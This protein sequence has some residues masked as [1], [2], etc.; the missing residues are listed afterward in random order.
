MD[1]KL[2][3]HSETNNR[4]HLNL[5]DWSQPELWELEKDIPGYSGFDRLLGVGGMGAVYRCQQDSLQRTV[6]IKI[7]PRELGEKAD[8]RKR[9]ERE[10]KELAALEHPNIV[11]VF[12]RGCSE[13]GLFYLVMEYVDGV[14]L[15]YV[16]EHKSISLRQTLLLMQKVCAALC[17]AHSKGVIHRDIKPENILISR[18]NQVRVCDFGLVKLEPNR[19]IEVTRLTRID[20]RVGTPIYA[21]PETTAKEPSIDQR[22]DIYSLGKV[23]LECLLGKRLSPAATISDAMVGDF[24]K[25]VGRLALKSISEAPEER[26]QSIEEFSN[27][28]TSILKDKPKP[29][30]ALWVATAILLAGAVIAVAVARPPFADRNESPTGKIN[31]NYDQPMVSKEILEEFGIE[32]ISE[33]PTNWEDFGGDIV[34]SNWSWR[35]DGLQH[36][37]SPGNSWA[38]DIFTVD[39]GV[40]EVIAHTKTESGAGALTNLIS[41]EK[42]AHG[43]RFLLKPEGKILFGSSIFQKE[44]RID[45]EAIPFDSENELLRQ[46]RFCL[47]IKDNRIQP[48]LN[49]RVIDNPTELNFSISPGRLQIG[50]GGPPGK[51]EFD[52][53]TYWAEQLPE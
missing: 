3:S 49:G 45:D 13:S 10:A 51:V 11:D 38:W 47:L 35:S 23:F 27:E 31:Q 18:D 32:K 41:T 53:V 20:Q 2:D 26:P 25:K 34:Y 44:N 22:S 1:Q 5:M 24:P 48:V 42:Q 40:V 39:N 4:P 8:F 28:I 17:Y 30:I 14:D 33:T 36:Y 12:D 15:A 6:A 37:E 46:H 29:G 50:P 21:A 7:L 16:I 52:R 9:F 19:A 43:V